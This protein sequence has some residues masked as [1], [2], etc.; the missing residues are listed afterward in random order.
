MGGDALSN[1]RL[2]QLPKVPRF[3]SETKGSQMSHRKPLPMVACIMLVNGRHEMVARAIASYRSQ[4][5]QSKF[6]LMVD[7]TPGG[8]TYTG[9]LAANEI[10]EDDFKPPESS[11]GALRNMANRHA[12]D[13]KADVLA[14]FDSDDWSH[15]RRLEEQVELMRTTGKDAVGYNDML[16]WD[17][18]WIDCGP[19]VAPAYQ[20]REAWLYE[21]HHPT[22]FLG[23][24]MMYK[25]SA[26]ENS[27]FHPDEPNEDTLWWGK[28][29]NRCTAVSSMA[30][31][32]L[33]PRMICAIHGANTSEAYAPAKRVPAHWRRMP[34]WD[35]YCSA[36]MT[37]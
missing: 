8:S 31:E 11:I 10:L 1:S 13:M 24:S 12:C 5:Y 6:L 9:Q 20:K 22:K 4:R 15:P 18:T 34:N 21:S 36:R 19:N 26:W 25:R 30:I 28:N 29:Q 14:H 33:Q 32:S 2:R 35:Q 37:L 7:S 27:P 17:T 23:S 16:F 3:Q